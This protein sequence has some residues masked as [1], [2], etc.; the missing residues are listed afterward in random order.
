MA[1]AVLTTAVANT[2]LWEGI[3]MRRLAILAGSVLLLAGC[4]SVSSRPSLDAQIEM[5]KQRVDA[6]C[7][8][9]WRD[10]AVYPVLYPIRSKI[11]FRPEDTTFEMLTDRSKPTDTER[12]AIVVF[13]KTKRAC[14]NESLSTMRRFSPPIPAQLVVLDEVAWNRFQFLLADL[15]GGLLTYGEFARKRQEQSAE[16]QAKVQQLVQLLAQ[17]SADAMYRAQQIANEARRAAAL[18]EQTAAQRR[19]E[20]QRAQTQPL[21]CTTTYFGGMAQTRCN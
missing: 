14:A 5:E 19:M 11:P 6:Y 16:H 2:I 20:W 8:G 9:L 12:A 4:G 15:H 7:D 1:Q 3:V 18:E 10:P 17:R 21:N 13:A